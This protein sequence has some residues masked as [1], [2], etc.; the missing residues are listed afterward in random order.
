MVSQAGWNKPPVCPA[1]CVAWASQTGKAEKLSC[2]MC[3]HNFQALD[4]F[5]FMWTDTDT[6]L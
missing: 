5:S 4:Q 3:K 6:A 1:K 2:K